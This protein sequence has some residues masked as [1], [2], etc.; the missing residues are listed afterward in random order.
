MRRDTLC[1]AVF[2]PN[3]G[4]YGPEKLRKAPFTECLLSTEPSFRYHKILQF[5]DL[6]CSGV[7]IIYLNTS[8]Y[9]LY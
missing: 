8:K 6:H 3:V 5:R 1:L 9:R 7:S 4:K 2:S